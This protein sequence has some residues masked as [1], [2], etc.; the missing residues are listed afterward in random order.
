MVPPQRHNRS[1]GLSTRGQGPAGGRLIS[2]QTWSTIFL[3]GRKKLSFYLLVSSAHLW[4]PMEQLVKHLSRC[5]HLGWM[6]VIGSSSAA[7]REGGDLHHLVAKIHSTCDPSSSWLRPERRGREEN[8]ET[9][10]A[11]WLHGGQTPNPGD[12][13]PIPQA[14]A[15]S[16]PHSLSA[17]TFASHQPEVRLHQSCRQ[18][19]T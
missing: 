1:E 6:E 11:Q 17:Q 16:A 19:V 7:H 18:Q 15:V 8:T 3:T 2:Q 13:I 12:G 9:E 14:Q 4:M 5:R 10:H